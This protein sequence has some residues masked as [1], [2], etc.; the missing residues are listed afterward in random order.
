MRKNKRYLFLSAIFVIMFISGCSN[1]GMASSWPGL[2]LKEEVGYF[3]YGTHVFALDVKNGGELWRFPRESDSKLQ[4]YAAP[5]IGQDLIV[6]GTYSN[7]LYSLDRDN[8]SEK[9]VFNKADDK[10]IAPVLVEDDMVYAPNTD[11]NIYAID[12]EGNIKWQYKTDGPNWTAPLSDGSRIYVAS[13]DHFLYA[14][15]KSY[16]P[17]ELETSKTGDQIVLKK[18]LWKIDLNAAVVAN[19]ILKNG[20]IYVATIS[21]NVHAISLAD[22]KILW[23]YSGGENAASIWGSPIIMDNTLL[24]GDENGDLYAISMEDGTPVW[25]VPYNAGASII[26]GGVETEE[27]LAVFI[28]DDGKVFSINLE[29]EPSPILTIDSKVYSSPVYQEGRIILAPVSKDTFFK[30]VD[31][32]G[33]DIWTF[34]PSN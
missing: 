13:M 34:N 1:A 28:T 20:V 32:N 29:K 16:Q 15:E 5:G 17:G 33:R 23:T 4:F 11:H 19:P 30:A 10:Y 26:A 3:S 25:A 14:F 31:L 21:G 12:I 27:G 9:W 2:S 6:V 18:P 24:Y 22:K 7:L 8:G